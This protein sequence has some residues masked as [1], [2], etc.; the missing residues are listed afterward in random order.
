ME[1][2]FKLLKSN[3][4]QLASVDFRFICLIG[5]LIF[6]PAFEAPKNL[7]ALL[8]VLSWVV[9]AKKNN[10]W[11]GQWRTID[12]IFLLWI[13]AA[14]IVSI[15]AMVSHQLYGGGFRD[16]T[17]FILIAWVVSRINFSTEK[18]IQLVMLS[19]L[20]T[21][22][23]LIYAYFEGNGV[24][25]ELHSV[26]HINHSAIYLLITYATS[27]ALLLFYYKNL[28]IYH[29][30]FLTLSSIFFFLSIIDTGSS[31]AFGILLFI[32][33]IYFIYLII[34]VKSMTLFLS[35]VIVSTV[36]AASF[37]HNP[38]W[39]LVKYINKG[40]IFSDAA[41][42]KILKFNYYAYKANPILG[43]GFKNYSQIKIDDIKKGVLEDGGVFDE[44]IFRVGAHTHNVY[45]NYLVSGG[46]LIFSIFVWFWLYIYWM[47]YKLVA[48]KETEWI[49]IS[50]ISVSIINLV[51]GWVNTTLHHEHAIL[52]MFILG[53]LIANFRTSESNNQL[54]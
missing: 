4:K 13:L 51:I 38:P 53:L 8:F 49:V 46:L 21:V 43:I 47:I 3:V 27:L 48:R 42:D 9:I 5:V 28:N 24:L 39:S 50:S 52:S 14:I 41:R 35:A 12:S 33:A 37:V 19:I 11:G 23:T 31:A 25:R 18:I 30:I 45:F 1:N 44:E 10:D 29:K 2:T 7:F 17:R 6:L 26:G 20:A 36:I 34:K 15:N 32:T 16:I 40:S 54:A 22:L